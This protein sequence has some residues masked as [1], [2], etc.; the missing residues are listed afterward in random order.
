MARFLIPILFLVSSVSWAK[1]TV[2]PYPEKAGYMESS[3]NVAPDLVQVDKFFSLNQYLK[4][5]AKGL[6]TS[7]NL[8][9][10]DRIYMT[11]K[12]KQSV[13]VKAR[14]K[15]VGNMEIGKIYQHKRGL[16]IHLR[17][18]KD[19]VSAFFFVGYSADVVQSMASQLKKRVVADSGPSFS[20]WLFP[21]AE[22]EEPMTLDRL[23]LPCHVKDLASAAA[24]V[25]N[26][27]DL[28]QVAAECASGVGE[29]LKDVTVDVIPTV[30]NGVQTIWN[31]AVSGVVWWF[32]TNNQQK[33]DAAVKTQQDLAT[34]ISNFPAIFQDGAAAWNMLPTSVQARV[35]CEV[36]TAVGLPT[37][38]AVLT[39]GST[40]AV[41]AAKIAQVIGKLGETLKIPKLTEL[42]ASMG[43]HVRTA[44]FAQ[45]AATVEG[46][47]R[48][49]RAAGVI[50]ALQQDEQKLRATV[51][52]LE[53]HLRQSSPAAGAA[54]DAWKRDDHQI[55]ELLEAQLRT[56]RING[57]DLLRAVTEAERANEQMDPE[58]FERYIGEKIISMP[59][60][61][62]SFDPT[63]L[64]T[65]GPAPQTEQ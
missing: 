25:A 7:P 57:N 11:K 32:T 16:L 58:Q 52:R 51:Q 28:M 63:K 44:S 20:D 35:I 17:E 29:G 10:L 36:V 45:Q 4:I 43:G 5:K 13:L 9:W 3:K 22:A 38:V 30:I 40:S 26:N 55:R 47:F 46:V 19:T 56:A 53:A 33:W 42:A 64:T 62:D 48:S 59:Y 24:P 21:R 49:T 6:P 50:N 23:G 14:V 61:C 15:L 65:D 12:T 54:L 60:L 37:L 34:V 31:G 8:Q 2:L 1:T 41:V 18:N 27:L 39:G